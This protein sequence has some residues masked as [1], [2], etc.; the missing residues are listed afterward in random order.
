MHDVTLHFGDIIKSWA[1]FS[2]L[3]TGIAWKLMLRYYDKEAP[4]PNDDELLFD[5]VGIPADTDDLKAKGKAERDAAIAA[6]RK[7][8]RLKYQLVDGVWT[9][10]R[11]DAEIRKYRHR[12]RINAYNNLQKIAKN[13]NDWRLPSFE[14]FAERFDHYYDSDLKRF[15]NLEKSSPII[16]NGKPAQPERNPKISDS[17]NVGTPEYPTPGSP[18]S[19]FP[20]PTSPLPYS[21][22]D[23]PVV[24]KGTDDV[25]IEPG[26]F[27][28]TI[29]ARSDQPAKPQ[30]KEGGAA[31]EGVVEMPDEWSDIRRAKFGEWFAHRLSLGK[32]ITP[33]QFASAIAGTSGLTDAQVAACIEDAIEK[34][35]PM[36]EPYKFGGSAR[37]FFDAATWI[38]DIYNAYPRKIGKP[39]AMR[40]IEKALRKARIAPAE[41]LKRTQTFAVAV[42]K[43]TREA[44]Y[45]REGA[46]TVPH[47]STWFNQHRF[48]DDPAEWEKKPR[49]QKKE[50][51]GTEV[52]IEPLAHEIEP[53]GWQSAF[54]REFGSAPTS[55]WKMLHPT[56]QETITKRLDRE[57]MEG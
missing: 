33:D 14:E 37:D 16:A 15:R 20:L 41:L 5:A 4:L 55:P 2:L 51:G 24:P 47:P 27:D 34:K 57:A 9:H 44:R 45:T 48:N 18:T 6:L 46:D 13:R 12:C 54:E 26:I 7:V 43:W 1:T 50:G 36:L 53:N 42:A 10:R 52:M 28:Q 23:T 3:E 38:E 32:F 8:L 56:T 35:S 40:A 21:Q 22:G 11:T 31:S 39:T 19:H 49:E 17:E 25:P 29:P 30:K